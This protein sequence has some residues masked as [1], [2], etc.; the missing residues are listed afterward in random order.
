MVAA[1]EQRAGAVLAVDPWILEAQCKQPQKPPT[2][3]LAWE[4]NLPGVGEG[5]V[6]ERHP[7]S[8]RQS[9]SSP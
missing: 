5:R 1:M 8:R 3:V 2:W 9:L 7:H 4:E 6:Q